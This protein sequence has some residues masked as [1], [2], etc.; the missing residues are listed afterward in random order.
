MGCYIKYN[1]CDM[2][3]GFDTLTRKR[4]FFVLFSYCKKY[5]LY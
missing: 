5:L 2:F 4:K 3:F 1:N